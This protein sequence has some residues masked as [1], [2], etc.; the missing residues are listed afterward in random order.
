EKQ[1]SIG[2]DPIKIFQHPQ[3]SKDY[4]HLKVPNLK[5][6]L[7][8]VDKKLILF[9]GRLVESKGL[10][11][12][13]KSFKLINKKYQ[14]VFLLVVGTGPKE[15]YYKA[16]VNDLSLQNVYFAGYVDNELKKAAYYKACD[17]FVLPAVFINGAYEPWGLV[18]NEAMAFGK[19]IVTTNAVGSAFDLVE[20]NVNGFVIR[21]GDVLDL[22]EAICKILADEDLI[23]KMGENSRKIY[24]E[25]NKYSQLAQVFIDAINFV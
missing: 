14:N 18:I 2:V 9:M 20:N 7:N 22:S 23:P 19:P 13:I 5:S 17:I 10:E 6:E 16:L 1:L 25:K 12:L 4:S 11:V 3:C 21:N 8:I 15:S 24:D